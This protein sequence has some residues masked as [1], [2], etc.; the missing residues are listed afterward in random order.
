M[1]P[2]DAPILSVGVVADTHIPDRARELHPKLIPALEAAKVGLILHAGDIST[3][4]VLEDLGHVAPVK[5][6]RGN[7]DWSFRDSL[8][9]VLHL[10]L[11]GVPVALMHGHGGWW[12]YIKD[13]GRY[14]FEGYQFDRYRKMVVELAADARVI[15]FGHTHRVENV[16]IG[17]RIIFNPGSANSGYRR[18]VLPSIGFLHFFA[19]GEVQGE[20]LN[21]TGY[22][23]RDG[24][25]EAAESS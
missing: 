5:A 22:Q 21:L 11:A 19:G 13:K 3:P 4:S 9:L 2:N 7:R 16:K 15:V 20:I 23:N 1:A 14:V 10:E 18:G 12:N 6:V 25:W 17:G 8:P 24:M